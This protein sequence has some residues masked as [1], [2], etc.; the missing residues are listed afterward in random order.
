M[1]NDTMQL[2]TSMDMS[3]R[4]GNTGPIDIHEPFTAVERIQQLNEID[5]VSYATNNLP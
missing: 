5:N 4:G 2:D 3:L 1:D